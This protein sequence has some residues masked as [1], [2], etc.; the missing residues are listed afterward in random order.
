MI[1][2]LNRNIRNRKKDIIIEINCFTYI[3]FAQK[4]ESIAEYVTVPPNCTAT[5]YFPNEKGRE[6]K[7]TTGYSKLIGKKEGY[8]LFE[9]PAGKYQFSN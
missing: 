5:I 8:S 7:E 3:Y 6:I 9:I 2:H 4:I 1:I